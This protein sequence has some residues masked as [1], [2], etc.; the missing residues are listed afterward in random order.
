M[1]KN[2]P[3]VTRRKAALPGGSGGTTKGGRNNIASESPHRTKA[4]VD[5]GAK[6]TTMGTR[7]ATGS[8]AS[9]MMNQFTQGK[10]GGVS[11]KPKGAKSAKNAIP[12][13]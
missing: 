7:G 2:A 5:Q 8:F 12:G 10:G 6:S 13:Y 1:A 4:A 11:G 3:P 9:V